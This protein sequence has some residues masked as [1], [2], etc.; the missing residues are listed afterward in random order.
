M[1]GGGG[2]VTFYNVGMQLSED[3]VNQLTVE[4]ATET[5]G[6]YKEVVQMRDELSR[7]AELMDG[8]VKREKAIMDMLGELQKMYDDQTAGLADAHGKFGNM[9]NHGVQKPDPMKDSEIEIQRIG[10]LLSSPA[11][12]PPQVP[13]HLQQLVKTPTKR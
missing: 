12:P 8:F 6:L 11:V 13:P 7:C 10:R 1:V 4:H 2:G 3:L 9:S 5:K